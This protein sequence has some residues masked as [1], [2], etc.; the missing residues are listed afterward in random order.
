[1]KTTF[2]IALMHQVNMRLAGKSAPASAFDRIH[3]G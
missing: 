2:H 3:H 1:M